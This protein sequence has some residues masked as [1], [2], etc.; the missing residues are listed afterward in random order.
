MAKLD[1]FT[2]K[3]LTRFVEEFQNKTGQLPVLQDFERAG[4]A[5]AVVDL[6]IK[7]G[8]IEQFYVTLSNGT[9]VKGYK[10]RL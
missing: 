5:R 7:D 1:V 2:Q 9:I 8:L 10:I 3:R 4:I 6:A